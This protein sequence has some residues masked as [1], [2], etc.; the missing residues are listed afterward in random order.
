MKKDLAIGHKTGV[1]CTFLEFQEVLEIINEIQKVTLVNV[2]GTPGAVAVTPKKPRTQL[3]LF[4]LVSKLAEKHK[5]P[6][7]TYGINSHRE[8]VRYGGD[9]YKIHEVYE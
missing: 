2:V 9:P 4:I 3:D 8:F 6:F 7:G 5:L 1:Y